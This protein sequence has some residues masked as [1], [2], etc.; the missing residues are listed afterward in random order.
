MEARLSQRLLAYFIDFIIVSVIL[1]LLTFWIP[2]SDKYIEA[3][4]EE[5]EFLTIDFQNE[6]I[7]LKDLYNKYFSIRYTLEK[8]MI[9]PTL[10]S[11]ILS[12]GYF[13]TFAYYKNGQTF[14]KKIMKI[15]IVSNKDNELNHLKLMG[16]A[17]IIDSILLSFLTV[18]FLTFITASQYSYTVYLLIV[19][20]NIITIISAFLII[21]R[22]DKKGLHDIMFD[23]KVIQA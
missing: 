19:C 13:A 22:K 15:K 12:L 23:T 5:E 11:A 14:G 1:S 16:R 18:L 6:D 10:I 7:S 20:Q 9:V 8:E 4:K 17:L 3:V 21:F 2:T